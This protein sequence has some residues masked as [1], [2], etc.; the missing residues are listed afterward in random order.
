MVQ[1]QNKNVEIREISTF[2]VAEDTLPELAEMPIFTGFCRLR[3]SE[4]LQPSP[5]IAIL[6]YNTASD[7]HTRRNHLIRL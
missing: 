2:L 4:N 5:I 1:M 7:I 6:F 3:P